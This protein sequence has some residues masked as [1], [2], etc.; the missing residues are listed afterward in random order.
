MPPERRSVY[1]AFQGLLMSVILLLF[2][3]QGPGHEGWVHRLWLLLGCLAGT[4]ALIRVVPDQ[5]LARGWFQA[6]LFLG[7]AVLATVILS[8]IRPRSEL[9]LIYTLIVFGSALTRSAKQSLVVAFVTIALYVVHWWQPGASIPQS[10]VFWLRFLFLVTSAA[11]L[12][13][14]ARDAQ[15]AQD[16]DK[17]RYDE[18]LIQVERLAT[19]GRVAA[20]VAH[21]IKGP[22]TTIAVNAEVAAHRHPGDETTLKELGQIGEE[23][24]RCKEIL[25]N[26]LDLGR[27]E[28]MDMEPLDLRVPA[29]RA[30]E[31][32][33][34]QASGRKLRLE[35]SGLDRAMK[36]RGDESLIQE[37]LYALLQNAV[38]A[39]FRGGVIRVSAETL[40]GRHLL[41]VSDDGA[42]IA[43]EDLERIFQP[44][45]TTK[46]D[47]SG[48]GLSAALRIAQKHGGTVEADSAG[49]GRG[50]TFTLVLPAS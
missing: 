33:R 12:A 21:R 27:I 23:V 34:A 36:A 41:R 49:A 30:L 3:Y 4:L 5:T 37:A 31:L 2:L 8:W 14:L 39:S 10:P 28:E 43:R 50:A 6:G 20:E 24:R 32:I 40:A 13:I 22:L 15:V 25:K 18:R 35:A 45:F 47:G 19:L 29:E 48:L 38:E 26:L 17:R 46:K 9:F 16:E 11:V 44:F 42:G 7:D 1:F